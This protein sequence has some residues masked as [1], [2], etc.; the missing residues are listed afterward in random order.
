MTQVKTKALEIPANEVY[1]ST[2]IEQFFRTLFLCSTAELVISMRDGMV[3]KLEIPDH[4]PSLVPRL[5]PDIARH[6]L[7]SLGIPMISDDNDNIYRFSFTLYLGIIIL[8]VNGCQIIDDV[9]SY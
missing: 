5:I 8:R 7:A 4:L 9:R 6:N 2:L 1:S 3:K